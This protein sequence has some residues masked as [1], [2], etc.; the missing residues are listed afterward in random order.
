MSAQRVSFS[1]HPQEMREQRHGQWHTDKDVGEVV[2]IADG[3]AG[4]EL[5]APFKPTAGRSFSVGAA[6]EDIPP[7]EVLRRLLGGSQSAVV[8][9]VTR[10]ARLNGP[11]SNRIERRRAARGTPVVRSADRFWEAADDCRRR[12][13]LRAG[14]G[15]ACIKH[16][17]SIAEHAAGFGYEAPRSCQ[18]ADRGAHRFHSSDAGI[19]IGRHA[20]SRDRL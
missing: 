19:E 12:P 4:T 8:N 1:I 14:Y 16:R 13:H 6:F 15:S 18:P 9:R 5:P 17:L 2:R 10:P 7:A 3:W 20:V 11:Q